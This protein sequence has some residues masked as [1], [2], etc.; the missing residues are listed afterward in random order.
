MEKSAATRIAE[1]AHM[2]GFMKDEIIVEVFAR[3]ER[4]YW[5]EFKACKTSE[6]R[7]RAWAKANLL[8]D[9]KNEMR[10]TVDA[11]ERDVWEAAKKVSP[12]APRT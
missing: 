10:V 4:K 3:L 7:V 9:I 2:Q 5:E 11:G 8:D 12:P 1:A 6:D